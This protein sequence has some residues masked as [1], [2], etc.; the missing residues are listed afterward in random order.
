MV[1]DDNARV[2]KATKEINYIDSLPY[3]SLNNNSI[4]LL[5]VDL[6]Y[7]DATAFVVSCYNQSLTTKCM[8]LNQKISKIDNIGSC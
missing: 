4:Y 6:G 2:Y 8:F 1:I 3:G 7:V 5:S